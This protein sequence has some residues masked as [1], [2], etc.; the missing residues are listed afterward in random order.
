MRKHDVKE[1]GLE[2]SEVI[3][4]VNDLY[5]GFTIQWIADIGFGEYNIYKD[6]TNEDPQWY[7]YSEYMDSNEDKEFITELMRLFIE[8]LVV[9]K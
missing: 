1:I 9:T 5:E 8:E 6:V 4:F 3:P 7:A 2:I